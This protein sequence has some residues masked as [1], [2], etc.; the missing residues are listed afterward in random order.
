MHRLQ[1]KG[2]SGS[3]PGT[4]LILWERHCEP[5]GRRVKLPLVSDQIQIPGLRLT[6]LGRAYDRSREL[7]AAVAVAVARRG[8]GGRVALDACGGRAGGLIS[9][10]S[11]SASIWLVLEQARQL[12]SVLSLLRLL[13][14]LLAA[15]LS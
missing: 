1:G 4:H 13:L 9:F 14:H 7:L 5:A 3:G 15:T 6:S 8:W 11:I 10:R 12:A 2:C